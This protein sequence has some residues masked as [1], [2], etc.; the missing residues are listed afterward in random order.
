LRKLSAEMYASGSQIHR[1][2]TGIMHY[3]MTT[4][5]RHGHRDELAIW[6][7]D[8]HRDL[9]AKIGLPRRHK[10]AGC[11]LDLAWCYGLHQ[12]SLN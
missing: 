4:L 8:R 2:K 10:G 5:Y 9:N 11:C 3:V 7:Y 1:A 6:I 12:I